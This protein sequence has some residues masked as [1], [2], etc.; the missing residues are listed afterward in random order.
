MSEYSNIWLCAEEHDTRSCKVKTDPRKMKC[1]LCVRATIEDDTHCPRDAKCQA[2]RRKIEQYIA[3]NDF[4]G[5]RFT[6]GR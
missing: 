3:N 2:Y 5:G 6:Y 1:A 4:G